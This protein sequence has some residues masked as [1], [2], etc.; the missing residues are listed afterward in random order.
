MILVYSVGVT[1]WL[2]GAAMG[3]RAFI[4]SHQFKISPIGMKAV[5]L[6]AVQWPI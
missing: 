1:E 6:W 4:L 2:R 5:Y 3:Y